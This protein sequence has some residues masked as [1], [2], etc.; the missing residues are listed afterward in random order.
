MSDPLVTT[1]WLAGRLD[2]PKVVV[3]DGS[4]HM[5]ASGRDARVE[6]A[7][8]HIPGGVFFG[9]D[10][11]CDH[12]SRLPH[13]LA[14]PAEFAVAVRRLGVSRDSHVVVYDS[15]GLFSAARVWWN[16]RVMGHEATSVLDGG[17]P[18]WIAEG[19]P[20]E[21]G[22]P[23]PVHGDFK[24]RPIPALVADLAAMRRAVD[25]GVPMIVDARAADRFSGTAP[26]PREG[27]R[28]GHMPGA[29]N[30]P[31]STVVRDGRLLEP[32]EL[33]AAFASAGVD[34]TIPIITTCGSGVSAALLALALARVGRE[35]AT[36]YDGSWSEW[37]ALADTAVATGPA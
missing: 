25:V 18:R 30:A 26:E 15:L 27:L 17:L 9:I 23:T 14:D 24:A 19:L 21:T 13:M 22:W 4:W 16:F 8:G 3:V 35:D 11:V 10:E 1:A 20:L 33:A 12:S 31:W 37:G 2:D 5:P 29:R 32:A 36:V 28:G 34:L 7:G 6:Y